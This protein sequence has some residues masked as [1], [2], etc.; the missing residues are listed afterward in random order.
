MK[1][2]GY[3][4][5]CERTEHKDMPVQLRNVETGETGTVIQCTGWDTPEA[6]L[7]RVGEEVTSWLPTEVEEVEAIPAGKGESHEKRAL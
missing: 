2:R 1:H 7:V 3:I 5:A 4:D 6:F